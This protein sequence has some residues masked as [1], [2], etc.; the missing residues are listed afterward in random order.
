MRPAP[1]HHP[2]FREI[3]LWRVAGGPL[4]VV[5]LLTGLV[6]GVL[7]IVTDPRTVAGSQAW[8]LIPVSIP[9]AFCLASGRSLLA[10]ALGG[11][12]A[13]FTAYMTVGLYLLWKVACFMITFMGEC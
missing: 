4:V 12:F 7:A 9:F 5:T 11:L 10:G 1:D 2:L 3:R 6:C 13:A 8:L